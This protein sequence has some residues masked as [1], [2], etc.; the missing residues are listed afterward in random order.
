MG[1]RR[2]L[3]LYFP[4][5]SLIIIQLASTMWTLQNWD[6]RGSFDPNFNQH[7]YVRAWTRVAPYAVGML[8]AFFHAERIRL[9]ESVGRPLLWKRLADTP[10]HAFYFFCAAFGLMLLVVFGVFG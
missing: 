10:L 8:L 4:S 7:L 5:F 3:E 6:I 2:W 1:P 9:G